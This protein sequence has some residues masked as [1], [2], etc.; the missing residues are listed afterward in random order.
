MLE[1]KEWEW[2]A[3]TGKATWILGFWLLDFRDGNVL[4][5]LTAW[6]VWK[7]LTDFEC[8]LVLFY[9]FINLFTGKVSLFLFGTVGIKSCFGTLGFNLGVVDGCMKKRDRYMVDHSTYC[10]CARLHPF[11]R[12]DQTVKYARRQGLKVINVAE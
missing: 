9:L 12:T 8:Q 6:F 7:E 10:I 2:C 3:E 4:A 5:T 1:N 11:S